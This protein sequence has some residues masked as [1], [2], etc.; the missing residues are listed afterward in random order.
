[1]V[2]TNTHCSFM[3]PTPPLHPNDSHEPTSSIVDAFVVGDEVSTPAMPA[4]APEPAPEPAP[5]PRVNQDAFAA[6]II[7]RRFTTLWHPMFSRLAAADDR[8]AAAKFLVEHFAEMLPDHTIRFGWGE[9]IDGCGARIRRLTRLLDSRLGWLGQDNSI[10]DTLKNRFEK[11][12][13]EVDENTAEDPIRMKSANLVLDLLPVN[14]DPNVAPLGRIWIRS[15]Q[16]DLDELQRFVSSVPPEVL[17]TT[18]TIFFSRPVT[19][20]WTHVANEVSKGW[21]R[22]GIIGIVLLLLILIACIPVS[23]RISATATVTAMDSR[24]VA[25]PIAA[26]LLV[27]HVQPGDRVRVGDSLLELDGRPLRIEL[28]AISGEIAE[29]TKDEDIALA[30]GQIAQA[31]LAGLKRQ[32]LSRRRDLISGRLDQLIVTSPIDGIVIQG[33][34]HHSL[35]TPLELGQ[36]LLEIAPQD[37]I[38]IELEIPEVEIG[39]VATSTPVQLW[40]PAI[41]HESFES[42]VKMIWPSAT[43]RDDQNV[44]VA[45]T[46]MP[47]CVTA[48][49][50]S[51]D[52]TPVAVSDATLSDVFPRSVEAGDSVRN[53]RGDRQGGQ[54]GLEESLRVGMRGEAIVFG[55]TRPWIWKWVRLP[56]RRIG[57]LIGW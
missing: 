15:P 45:K 55:P 51:T 48:E 2:I 19:T 7:A 6:S 42:R 53:R 14:A 39:Y 43:I 24:R 34:L 29:A 8:E 38:E 50:V 11:Q 52:N 1:M 22:R 17:C 56:L 16:E 4:V 57:W 13:S 12:S 31:Q 30:S 21:S 26:T 5:A 33:D 49:P 28:E 47:T 40:F 44:F 32:T 25:A 20:R 3:N 10:Y 23:Y 9:R 54:I 36:T 46:P 35:G 37:S 18:A 41:G 27:A